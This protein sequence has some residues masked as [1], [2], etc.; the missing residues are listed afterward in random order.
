MGEGASLRGREER[1]GENS[2]KLKQ[3]TVGLRR[4]RRR[5]DQPTDIDILGCFSADMQSDVPWRFH[6][7]FR[8][9]YIMKDYFGI[10]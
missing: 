7:R 10:Y 6:V 1:E 4:Q 9:V 3:T 2:T 8:L 5:A